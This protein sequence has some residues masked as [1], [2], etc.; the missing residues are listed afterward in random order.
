MDRLA[1]AWADVGDWWGSV[2]PPQATLI[3]GLVVAVIATATVTQRYRADRRE[4]R[5]KRAQWA[6]D[7]TLGDDEFGQIVGWAAIEQLT[8][9]RDANK[10]DRRWF[11]GV[12]DSA[13][14][15]EADADGID[16]LIGPE[17]ESV[18]VGHH[19][20]RST[21]EVRGGDGGQGQGGGS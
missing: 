6:L 16:D 20:E 9:S 14:A 15:L 2:T 5:W 21:G 4:Q 3:T 13:L 1:E 18:A 8:V 19:D 11:L 7:L 17:D 10:A 12:V